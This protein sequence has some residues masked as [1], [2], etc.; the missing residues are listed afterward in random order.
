[1]LAQGM[2][3]VAS[4]EQV[5]LP[6]DRIESGDVVYRV[7]GGLPDVGLADRDLLI[8]EPRGA[9]A[10][11]EFVL[12]TLQECAFVGRWWTKHG[13]RML[14]D[15]EFR[16]IADSPDLAVLGAVTLIARGA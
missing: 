7:A 6:G 1:M 8:I 11:G 15:N 13:T 3:I 9:A 16:T 4:E 14:M 10:T 2:P 5:T 12:A